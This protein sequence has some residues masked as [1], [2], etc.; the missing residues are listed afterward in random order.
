MSKLARYVRDGEGG[1]PLFTPVNL[2]K[3]YCERWPSSGV[4]TIFTTSEQSVSNR[5]INLLCRNMQC[6]AHISAS[7][8]VWRGEIPLLKLRVPISFS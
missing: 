8:S 5:V 1:K 6:M 3:K 2:V 7:N 4:D